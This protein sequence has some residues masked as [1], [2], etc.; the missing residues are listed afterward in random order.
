MKKLTAL[1]LNIIFTVICLISPLGTIANAT[2]S[3]EAQ[4]TKIGFLETI[5]N[6]SHLDSFH[7]IQSIYGGFQVNPTSYYNDK[8]EIIKGD[9][10]ININNQLK[11]EKPFESNTKSNINGKVN[12]SYVS[13][14]PEGKPFDNLTFNS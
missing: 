7:M 11:S 4:S 9:Y 1:I 2:S 12:V 10:R 3:P 13:N 14:D 6:L 8:Q 5:D